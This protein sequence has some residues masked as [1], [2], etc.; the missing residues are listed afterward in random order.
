HTSVGVLGPIVERWP[1]RT[2]AWPGAQPD[3]VG[4]ASVGDDNLVGDAIA[5]PV[6]RQCGCT[7]LLP[8]RIGR[9]NREASCSALPAES[10]GRITGAVRIAKRD[11]SE[12]RVNHIRA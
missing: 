7:H 2:E 1:A 9:T 11:R 6:A 10:G 4:R 5:V 8:I 3:I 12:P